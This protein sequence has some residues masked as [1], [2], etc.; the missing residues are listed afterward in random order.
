MV[1]RLSHLQCASVGR[2]FWILQGPSTCWTQA[3]LWRL[4]EARDK[5]GISD[6]AWNCPFKQFSWRNR[7]VCT[8]WSIP[9]GLGPPLQLPSA[10]LGVGRAVG[11][12]PSCCKAVVVLSAGGWRCLLGDC[13]CL[14]LLFMVTTSRGPGA[15]AGASAELFK[16]RWWLWQGP[17][18]SHAQEELVGP[19][20][21]MLWGLGLQ[22]TPG[23]G[24]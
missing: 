19:V 18:C 5:V 9:V 23:C 24:S 12:L 16:P 4:G 2:R 14:R 10:G 17:T 8:A 1:I 22:E 13:W 7:G 21:C 11:G 15:G 6:S 3:E 20:P